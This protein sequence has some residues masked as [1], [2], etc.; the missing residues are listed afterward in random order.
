M[1]GLQD[2]GVS[3]VGGS[4]MIWIHNNFHADCA[5]ACACACGDARR[6]GGGCGGGRHGGARLIESLATTAA[7]NYKL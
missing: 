2:L 3:V 4:A 5:C 6:S 7:T 1:Q